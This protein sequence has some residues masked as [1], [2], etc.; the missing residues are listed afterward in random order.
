MPRFI[1]IEVGDFIVIL[2]PDTLVRSFYEVWEV[3]LGGTG[4]ESL[5]CLVPVNKKHVSLFPSFKEETLR[6]LGMTLIV[7][8][9]F[10]SEMIHGGLASSFRKVTHNA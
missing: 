4:E 3:H 7:P 9:R 6:D 8:M 10:L 5:V 2:D 1:S